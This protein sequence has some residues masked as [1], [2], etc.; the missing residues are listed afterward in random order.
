[1]KKAV[2]PILSTI[3][4]IMAI[5]AL[6]LP[7]ATGLQGEQGVQ[8]IQG[9]Q[10]LIGLTGPAGEDGAQGPPGPEGPEGPEGPRGLKGAPGSDADCDALEDRIAELEA[11][12][13]ALEFTP[14]TID[15]VIS[16]CEW[17]CAADFVGS[18][19]NVYVLND[20]EYLYVAFEANCGDYTI[21]SSMTNIYTYAGGD[22]AGEC[23]AHTVAGWV[24][25][26]GLDYFTIHHIQPPKV[27][28]GKEARPTTAIVSIASTVMEWRIPLNEFTMDL[29]DS[30]A[31]D[32]MSYSE[33]C[34]DWG[35]AWLYEQCYTLL[36]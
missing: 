30:L 1:M 27:K 25:D 7:A 26:V 36:D 29:S 11:R 6:F 21:A 31:F 4:L 10:G 34:S 2:F 3:A 5:I 18:N 22:Y 15:G 14:P 19:Y 24:G 17:T 35:T 9:E 16:P 12:I 32:F 33:G 13:D 23:W 8:G 20:A 28:E